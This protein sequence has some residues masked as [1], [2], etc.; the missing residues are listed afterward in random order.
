MTIIKSDDD[1][2]LVRT[3]RRTHKCISWLS[4][5]VA[6]RFPFSSAMQIAAKARD[7]ERD[8]RRSIGDIAENAAEVRAGWRL[9]AK[10]D[11]TMF[12]HDIVRVPPTLTSYLHAMR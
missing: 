3:L 5:A 11:L 12:Q 8:Q 2:Y 4:P 9:N 6:C 1:D 7:M 10:K